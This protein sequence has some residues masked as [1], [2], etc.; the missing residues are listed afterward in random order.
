[1]FFEQYLS[2][3]RTKRP[4]QF[5]F[6]AM[7]SALDAYVKSAIHTAVHG[8]NAT[9]G[10]MYEFE[11]LFEAQVEPHVRDIVLSRSTDL[12]NQYVESG[13]YGSLLTDIVQSPY[14]PEM[15]FTAK[16]DVEGVPLLGKPD[17]RY[18]TK[19]G[20]HVISDWKVN[21]SMSKTGAS[22]TQGFK[23]CRDNYKSNTHGK[24]FKARRLKTDQP[25]KVYKD[26]DPF[27]F[28]GLE[29]NRRYLD[30]YSPDWAT[31]LA[32]YS[33]LLGEPIGGEDY[34]IRMEQIA[35]RPVKSQPLPRAKFAT[36]M[37]RIGKDFQIEVLTRVK[38][39]WETILSGH[40]F[41]DV[42]RER[43]DE[44]CD[45]LVEKAQM[46][47]GLHPALTKSIGTSVRFK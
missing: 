5:D 1:M 35:C 47:P 39:C 19:E 31:Q 7:G 45:Q 38:M 16:G 29:I 28:K 11:T 22:P 43:S 44:I 23:I 6:M 27:D 9:K 15:E 20:I 24:P 26:Y 10:T 37:S 14:A 18:I 3:V 40:I 46:P 30:E 21:G 4:P 17:L 8:E 33:W 34:V 2:P 13:A 36:H 12:W 41:T 42:N 25:D 32:I